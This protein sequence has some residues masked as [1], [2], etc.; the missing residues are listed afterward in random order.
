MHLLPVRPPTHLDIYVIGD[1]TIHERAVV[2]AG[3]VLQATPGSRIVI[4]EGACIGMGSI[5]TACQGE[6]EV[7]AG[8]ILGA[9]VLVVGNSKIGQNACVGSGTTIFNS[10]VEPMALV[11]A[12]SLMGD[13]SPAFVCEEIDSDTVNGSQNKPELISE[14]VQVPVSETE[15][16]AAETHKTAE[17]PPDSIKMPVIGQ[18]YIKQMLYTLFPERQAF[19]RSQNPEQTDS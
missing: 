3:T 15:A 17:S 8:A 13:S 14:E 5:L 18:V 16:A 2:A 10:S 6:I 12:G 4:G 11:P 7:E 9:G 19:N 1:V